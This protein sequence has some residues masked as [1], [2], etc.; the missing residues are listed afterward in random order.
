VR[1]WLTIYDVRNYA[2][3]DLLAGVDILIEHHRRFPFAELVSGTYSLRN[4]DC[5]FHEAQS[6]SA[7]RIAVRPE[8]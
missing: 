6:S 1:R 5:T 8:G 7:V 2:P 3:A 4:A